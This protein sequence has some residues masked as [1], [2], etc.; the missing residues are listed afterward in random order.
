MRNLGKEYSKHKHR[1]YAPGDLV[2]WSPERLAT[3]ASQRNTEES[4]DF[5]LRMWKAAI[6]GG[7]VKPMRG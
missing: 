1:L 5:I 6:A 3:A 7:Y 4:S 2:R